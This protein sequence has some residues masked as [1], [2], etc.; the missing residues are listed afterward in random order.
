MPSSDNELEHLKKLL[1]RGDRPPDEAIWAA[2]EDLCVHCGGP[3]QA[4]HELI[5]RSLAPEGWNYFLNRVTLCL[6]DHEWAQEGPL[7]KALQLRSEANVLLNVD[8]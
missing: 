5:P 8:A 6:A 1:L 3:A 4:I 2:Y 7:D